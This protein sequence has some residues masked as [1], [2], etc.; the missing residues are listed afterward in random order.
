[1]KNTKK[2]ISRIIAHRLLIVVFA[3]F[4]IAS[5]VT[6]MI[7]HYSCVLRA[8]DLLLMTCMDAESDLEEGINYTLQ[9]IA[10]EELDNYLIGGEEAVE[11]YLKENEYS[12]FVR[13]DGTI[14]LCADEANIGKNIRDLEYAQIFLDDLNDTE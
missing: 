7:L 5:F 12:Y 10:F 6:Y 2:K 1:M 8:H 13:E 9:D 3:A 14:F 11:D 4:V